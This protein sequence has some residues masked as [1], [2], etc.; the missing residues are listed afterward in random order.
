VIPPGLLGL[1]QLKVAGYNPAVLSDEVSPS[2][3]LE[4]WWLRANREVWTA[5]SGISQGAG[6]AND[7]LAFSPNTIVVPDKEWWFV[8][9]YS[10]TCI[11]GA[12]STVDVTRLAMTW[13]AAG[14]IRYQFLGD[15]S[16]SVSA[17]GAGIPALLLAE[18][19]W[20]P[21]GATLGF[22]FG[23]T[24]VVGV[25]WTVRGLDFTRCPL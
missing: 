15:A 1:L 11:P 12:A 7:F 25:S 20:A 21:P 2:I 23:T 17:A 22:W 18:K 4:S 24:T 16:A 9:S 8:H 14:T 6:V 3:D 5:N 13:N 19:F 10:V